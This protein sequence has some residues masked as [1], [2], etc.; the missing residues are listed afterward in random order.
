M[1]S[2]D[3]EDS[4]FLKRGTVLDLS[5]SK[6]DFSEKCAFKVFVSLA[7]LDP[8]LAEL[9][10]DSDIN[11]ISEA[12]FDKNREKIDWPFEG[13]V[14]A[15]FGVIGSGLQSN[16]PPCSLVLQ[17]GGCKVSGLFIISKEFNSSDIL[18]GSSILRKYH[19]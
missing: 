10:S 2:S 17:I 8:V 7:G 12:Y 14:P 4:V 9:D 16:Y 11:L 18:I 6:N 5:T 15:K 13:S 19:M 3:L 1:C